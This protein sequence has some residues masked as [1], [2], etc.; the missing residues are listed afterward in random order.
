MPK[1]QLEGIAYVLPQTLE[2]ETISNLEELSHLEMSSC[3]DIS[4]LMLPID[5]CSKLIRTS[6]MIKRASEEEVMITQELAMLNS[7]LVEEH[8][9]VLQQIKVMKVSQ[10]HQSTSYVQGCLNL[11]NRR[12]IL[13]ESRLLAFSKTVSPYHKPIIPNLVLLNN[14][15]DKSTS[16]SIEADLS[17]CDDPWLDVSSSSSSDECTDQED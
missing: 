11:L 13:C 4:T 17:D 14:D 6:N 8:C 1:D 9:S 10:I 7:Q 16:T 12:L 5:V 2:W 3:A 15:H